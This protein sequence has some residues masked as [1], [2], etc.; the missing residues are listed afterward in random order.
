[1]LIATPFSFAAW[2]M[3]LPEWAQLT[4]FVTFNVVV[5]VP[6]LFALALRV[7]FIRRWIEAD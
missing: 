5:F 7:P 6:I 3:S 1:M 4:I 2:L